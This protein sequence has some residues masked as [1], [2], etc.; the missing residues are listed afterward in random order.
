MYHQD[1]ISD[2][3]L[4]LAEKIERK[5]VKGSLDRFNQETDAKVHS[6]IGAM[7]KLEQLSS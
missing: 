4:T 5:L 2:I 1:S 7:N 6:L 3:V